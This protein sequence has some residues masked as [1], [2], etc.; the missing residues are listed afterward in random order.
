MKL[1]RQ[2]CRATERQKERGR[3]IARKHGL[4]GITGDLPPG[5]HSFEKTF[6]VT[7]KVGYKTVLDSIDT[8]RTL[9]REKETLEKRCRQLEIIPVFEGD[10]I[11]L[12]SFPR[13]NIIKEEI[14]AVTSHRGVKIIE[15]RSYFEILA[16]ITHP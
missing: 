15:K 6:M 14:I 12:E 16:Y 10:Y 7:R 2:I 8:Y 13:R 5:S 11:T 3:E 4:P 9:T 1:F